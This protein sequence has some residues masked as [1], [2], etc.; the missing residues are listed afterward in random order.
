MPQP[1]FFPFYHLTKNVFFLFVLFVRRRH[2]KKFW[3]MARLGPEQR[4]G[5]PRLPRAALP[6]RRGWEPRLFGGLHVLWPPGILG[7]GG[8]SPPGAALLA[9]D[10]TG[11]DFG[12]TLTLCAGPP[13]PG[14]YGKPHFA[15][16]NGKT[17]STPGM[18]RRDL[19]KKI[20]PSGG[21]LSRRT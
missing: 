8:N 17:L 13:H 20:G 2:Q 11:L 16:V 7:W 18:R 15:M 1:L 10:F 12:P 14:C 21:L 9:P 4:G 5:I 6:D 19:K 3:T